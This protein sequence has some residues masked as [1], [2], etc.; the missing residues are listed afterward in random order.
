MAKEKK[1]LEL[2]QEVKP[3]RKVE[4]E[5]IIIKKVVAITDQESEYL[6]QIRFL[7]EDGTEITYKPKETIEETEKVRGLSVIKRYSKSIK[8]DNA[9]DL[10]FLINDEINETGFFKAKVNY[11]IM[12]RED[13]ENGDVKEFKFFTKTDFENL[14]K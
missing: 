3:F 9:P 5:K 8:M 13:E 10:I 4:S 11:T 14:G 6:I 7:L 1:E 12:S 2:K